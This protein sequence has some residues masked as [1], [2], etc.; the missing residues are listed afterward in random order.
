VVHS[1]ATDAAQVAWEAEVKQLRLIHLGPEHKERSLEAAR[2]L[3]PAT[4][5]AQ[6]G[7]TIVLAGR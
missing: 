2:A 5:L 7:E 3:F 6:E 4:D 1:R